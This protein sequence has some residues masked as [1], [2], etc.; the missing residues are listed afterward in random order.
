[1][2]SSRLK[3]RVAYG[4]CWSILIYL[5]ILTSTIYNCCRLLSGNK[6]LWPSWSIGTAD[7]LET[8]SVSDFL[9]ATLQIHPS[10]KTLNYKKLLITSSILNPKIHPCLPIGFT[11]VFLSCNFHTFLYPK[12][13]W[14]AWLVLM[15]K[16]TYDMNLCLKNM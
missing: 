2:E 1:M 5:S 16:S 11:L 10:L 8:A 3:Q 12:L 15:Y 9:P 7:P 14:Y 6:W 13:L 4:V